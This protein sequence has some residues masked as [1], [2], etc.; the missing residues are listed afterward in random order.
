MYLFFFF[1]F[2]LFSFIIIF[3]LYF[4]F[5]LFLFF[6]HIIPFYNVIYSGLCDFKKLVGAM[7]HAHKN[8][9]QGIY[10]YL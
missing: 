3:K 8:M 5:I 2:N 4:I 1:F 10:F 9:I 7:Y 6:A